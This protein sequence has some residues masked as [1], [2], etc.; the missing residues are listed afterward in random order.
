MNIDIPDDINDDD[1]LALMELEE[2]TEKVLGDDPLTVAVAENLVNILETAKTMDVATSGG[3]PCTVLSTVAFSDYVS[4]M[5]TFK[6]FNVGITTCCAAVSTPV[7]VCDFNSLYPSII[8]GC[9]LDKNTQ[10]GDDLLFVGQNK[11]GTSLEKHYQVTVSES[12]VPADDNSTYELIHKDRA[13]SGKY[14]DDFTSGD[15]RPKNYVPRPTH[16][17]HYLIC[18]A[19]IEVIGLKVKW[20]EYVESDA[21]AY[22]GGLSKSVYD[23]TSKKNIRYGVRK[24]DIYEANLAQLE[25]RVPDTIVDSPIE[26]ATGLRILVDPKPVTEIAR[27]NVKVKFDTPKYQLVHVSVDAMRRIYWMQPYMM[28]HWK[29]QYDGPI[30]NLIK[31]L[32]DDRAMYKKKG[33]A[34]EDPF[35]KA[36]IKADEMTVKTAT[37]SVYGQLGRALAMLA[38]RQVAM[39]VTSVGRSSILL[40]RDIVTRLFPGRSFLA[41]CGITIDKFPGLRARLVDPPELRVSAELAAQFDTIE[42]R[43][44]LLALFEEQILDKYPI[45]R[46]CCEYSRGRYKGMFVLNNMNIVQNFLIDLHRQIASRSAG[47]RAGS[48][49][50]DGGDSPGMNEVDSEYIVPLRFPINKDGNIVIEVYGED[51]EKQFDEKK[52]KDVD[53]VTAKW[54]IGRVFGVADSPILAVK[55]RQGRAMY[56]D[57]DSLFMNFVHEVRTMTGRLISGKEVFEHTTILNASLV[58]TIV[59]GFIFRGMNLEYEKSFARFVQFE[60]KQYMGDKFE[61]NPKKAKFSM[62]GARFSR[63]G[64]SIFGK[65]TCEQMIDMF[66]APDFSLSK[67]YAFLMKLKTDVEQGSAAAAADAADDDPNSLLPST[68]VKERVLL[69]EY[70]K[71]FERFAISKAVTRCIDPKIIGN[72]LPT[73]IRSMVQCAIAFREA[74]KTPENTKSVGSKIQYVHA[75]PPAG[76]SFDAIAGI[77][78]I[79]NKN[80]GPLQCAYDESIDA[81]IAYNTLDDDGKSTLDADGY[82]TVRHNPIIVDIKPYM[83]KEVIPLAVMLIRVHGDVE[84][85]KFV[86]S[87][88]NRPNATSIMETVVD[89]KKKLADPRIIEDVDLCSKLTDRYIECMDKYIINTLFG[90][91]VTKISGS[92]KQRHLA[93]TGN[94]RI[95]TIFSKTNGTSVADRSAAANS[96]SV[97]SI[98][99]LAQKSLQNV[100]TEKKKAV[101][102]QNTARLF[103][104]EAIF[105]AACERGEE[106]DSG[107]DNGGGDGGDGGY[108]T[109]SILD[110]L[111]NDASHIEDRGGHNDAIV[112][113][114]RLDDLLDSGGDSGGNRDGDRDDGDNSFV[115]P[116]LAKIRSTAA[117]AEAVKKFAELSKIVNSKKK[118]E[119]KTKSPKTTKAANAASTKVA[120]TKVASTKAA[121]TDKISFFLNK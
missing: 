80:G 4:H 86:R 40:I 89:V 23:Y 1:L 29:P 102:L 17:K 44:R 118:S 60:K 48:G 120:S 16:D 36:V 10:L 108:N 14:Y 106:E 27:G 79:T 105:N 96:N 19:D 53:V 8:V 94:T 37:N 101:N 82:V 7:A 78:P 50:S 73:A 107:D 18:A 116:P 12:T 33:K 46:E 3:G 87:L 30:L 97:S 92:S 117:H 22:I 58:A 32:L 54:G 110:D 25:S 15:R 43:E 41:Y 13:T 11:T 24:A 38:K 88:P 95:N 5:K 57:T 104:R 100:K 34:E 111:L 68:K 65:E 114:T 69:S 21:A 9:C 62:S 72:T 81:I 26:E 93:Q 2:F 71:R 6:D 35:R 113:R 51:K 64:F 76:T 74:M 63:R 115:R 45:V 75:I 90:A 85:A 112:K 103:G 55:V 31:K 52:G 49:G 66:Y 39:T 61:D 47:G 28:Y 20:V 91:F 67:F 59:S 77:P 121:K 109:K 83:E 119:S 98:Q 99:N 42:G 84:V 70:R 56:G